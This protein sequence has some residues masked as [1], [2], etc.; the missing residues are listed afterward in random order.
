MKILGTVIVTILVVI[1]FLHSDFC[2]WR[3]VDRSALDELNQQVTSLNAQLAARPSVQ[4]AAQAHSGSWMWD[5]SYRTALEKT[6]IVG[7]PEDAKSRD[8]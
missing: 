4:A 7:V 8:R 2:P 1:A 6:T 3:I 5:P